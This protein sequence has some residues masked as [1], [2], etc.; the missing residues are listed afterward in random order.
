MRA[1]A[2]DVRE[3]VGLG[4]PAHLDDLCGGAPCDLEHAHVHGGC[5]LD[6]LAR[7]G[8]VWGSDAIEFKLAWTPWVRLKQR[9][10]PLL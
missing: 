9:R 7:G 5:S 10:M 8:P 3:V 6:E 2:R 4:R 1:A